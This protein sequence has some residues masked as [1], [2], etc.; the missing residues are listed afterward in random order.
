MINYKKIIYIIIFIIIII[1][2]VII[3]SRETYNNCPSSYLDLD[4][5][6]VY[7]RVDDDGTSCWL[8]SYG[9]GA[10]TC[11]CPDG[12]TDMGASCAKLWNGWF[13]IDSQ[14]C[15]GCPE[16]EEKWGEICY[17]KCA[18]GYHPDGCCFCA[19]DDLP[20]GEMILNAITRDTCF[21]QND[22]SW[23]KLYN[24]ITETYTNYKNNNPSKIY[25]I[26]SFFQAT[27]WVGVD[28]ITENLTT[29]PYQVAEKSGA[30]YYVKEFYKEKGFAPNVTLI[31]C[32]DS[33]FTPLL[34]DI[35]ISN[36]KNI[37]GID[38]LDKV[39]INRYPF[40]GAHD[41]ATGYT[42]DNL[43]VRT[44]SNLP[45]IRTQ[46][47]NFSD[48][49]DCGIRYYDC[50]VDFFTSVIRDRIPDWLQIAM[51]WS[52]LIPPY[53]SLQP[54]VLAL[55]A[56]S[57][58]DNRACF[59]HTL[60]LSYVDE[61]EGFWNMINKAINKREL[62]FLT[63]GGCSG[64]DNQIKMLKYLTD[65]FNERCNNYVFI[66]DIESI[67]NSYTVEFYKQSEKYILC[68]LK[69]DVDTNYPTQLVQ[70]NWNS[71]VQCFYNDEDNPK[72]NPVTLTPVKNYLPTR[73]IPP[74][75]LKSWYLVDQA[76]YS[77]KI[78]FNLEGKYHIVYNEVNILLDVTFEN[79]VVYY[80]SKLGFSGSLTFG[81]QERIID[82]YIKR[83]DGRI[84]QFIELPTECIES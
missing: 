57:L 76:L 52:V 28:R 61:D 31:D 63:F 39:P 15:G 14:R 21:N 84:L 51:Y 54:I 43:I 27:E 5:N 12:W 50:R 56:D 30:V 68:Y 83:D 46:K 75:S 55:Q 22:K 60:A 79:S 78:T 32:V 29:Q 74:K 62:V 44:V 40:I 33:K 80:T 23:T 72:P 35:I 53:I 59:H 19:P 2:I 67:Q 58:D 4:K 64:Q 3:A 37:Y 69:M 48:Q 47:I 38:N 45:S 73:P 34:K 24:Y 65:L 17:P 41:A 49:Y 13:P 16:N 70:D 81:S 25:V 10:G 1:G 7:D 18:K 9:R 6:K 66:T 82:G 36:A 77:Y 11:Y 8:R 26:Q 42:G 20:F 71:H